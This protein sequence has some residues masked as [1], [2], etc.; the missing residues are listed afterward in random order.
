LTRVY[1]DPAFRPTAAEIVMVHMVFAIML[2][3]FSVRNNDDMRVKNDHNYKSNMHYHY[4][5]SMFY[6]LSRSHTVEDVQAMTL[7]CLHLR[8]FPK[9]GASWILT[10]TTLALALEL[11]LNRS[12]KRWVVESRPNLLDIE[13]RKRI[14]WIILAIDVTLSGKLGRPMRLRYEDLDVE[15]PE[16][17]DDELL[18]EDGL[19][20]SR[21]G[22]CT[23]EIGLVAMRILPLFMELYSTIYA[24]RRCPENYIKTVKS[25]EARVQKWKDDLPIHLQLTNKTAGT[26]NR[27]FALYAEM[28]YLEFRLLLR[29]PSVEMTEDK[30]FKAE[31]IR[32]CDDCS[33]QMLKCVL[34]LQQYNTL[35]TTWYNAAVYLMAITATL[36][37]THDKKS[38][39][40][41]E[42]ASLRTDMDK[43]LGV[44]GDVGRLLGK[45]PYLELRTALILQGSGDGLKEAVRG[46][47]EGTL[48]MLDRRVTTPNTA[49]IQNPKSPEDSKLQLQRSNSGT[50]FGTLP[51]YG[52]EQ[53]PSSNGVTSVEYSQGQMSHQTTPYPA[54]TVYSTYAETPSAISYAPHDNSNAFANYPTGNTEAPLVGGFEMTPSQPQQNNQW[55]RSMSIN[56]PGAQAWQQWTHSIGQVEPQDRYSASALIQLGA[57]G[58][59][60]GINGAQT[61]IPDMNGLQPVLGFDPQMGHLHGG[62]NTWPQSTF[63]EPGQ[64]MGP[65]S[66]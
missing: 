57:R 50:V 48:G 61:T 34:E 46:V 39:S 32:A 36:F 17:M 8:N 35:D 2:F 24:V 63:L 9:P 21:P 33:R 31:G 28:W 10:Q 59:A 62:I 64:G 23:H 66:G 13:M 42:I 6:Q 45:S 7:I 1:D 3:Q 52:L 41:G 11:G 19:D 54:A 37:A 27:P 16:V 18:S 14:F 43:W 60:A 44:M 20:M 56:P 53:N 40:P 5:L 47:I 12:A 38:T 65:G 58:N 15:F 30:A 26:E 25:L 51:G 55:Q 4:S 22:T 29:H 49:Y